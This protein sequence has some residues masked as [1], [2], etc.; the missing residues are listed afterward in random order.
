MILVDSSVWIDFFKK[1]QTN[2]TK[3]LEDSIQNE[4]EVFITEIIY[5]EILL[6]IKDDNQYNK[7]KSILEQLSFLKPKSIDTYTKAVEIFR[8]CRS[9]GITI[10]STIDC[11][12]SS[13]AIENNISL[14]TSDKDF[15]GIAK[16]TNLS[17]Y[18][19]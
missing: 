8:N 6:G 16:Y 14:L 12:I 17:I 1:N 19:S 13:I 18:N 11:I 7:T 10:R 9:K 15:I 5:T 3:I 4:I 2:Q